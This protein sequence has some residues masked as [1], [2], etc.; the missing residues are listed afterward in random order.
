MSLL[1]KTKNQEPQDIWRTLTRNKFTQIYRCYR[2]R[3]MTSLW[4]DF[5]ASRGF[6]QVQ[7]EIPCQKFL[8]SKLKRA[9]INSHQSCCSYVNSSSSSLRLNLFYKQISLNLIL[10]VRNGRNCR[11]KQYVSEENQSAPNIRFQ[12]CSLLFWGLYN[13]PTIWILNSSSF[14]PIC[15]YYSPNQYLRFFYCSSGL[16]LLKLKCLFS[17]A[18]QAEAG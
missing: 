6:L 8:Q 14:S 15:G 7:S 13:L 12:S 2:Y 9:Y 3:P 10:F 5:L 11:Q 1:R 16:E 17:E 4:F 18:W